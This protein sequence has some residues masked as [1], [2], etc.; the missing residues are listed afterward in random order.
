MFR[1]KRFLQSLLGHAHRGRHVRGLDALE[2][3]V[4]DPVQGLGDQGI[5]DGVAI[6]AAAHLHPLGRMALDGFPPG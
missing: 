3:V 5:A 4:M 1:G 6:G 2:E